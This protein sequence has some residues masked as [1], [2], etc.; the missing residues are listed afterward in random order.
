MVPNE[1]DETGD[2]NQKIIMNMAKKILNFKKF[3]K[4][5]MVDRNEI[6]IGSRKHK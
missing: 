3:P 6:L 1:Y 2:L 4:K 5:L